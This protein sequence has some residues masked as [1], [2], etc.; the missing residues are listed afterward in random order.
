MHPSAPDLT[1]ILL[2]I[3]HMATN[4]SIPEGTVFT[5]F[6]VL[7]EA[8]PDKDNR[9]RVRAVCA[10]GTQKIVYVRHLK[11]GASRS[12]GCKQWDGKHHRSK[13]RQ[14][15]IWSAMIQ[16]CHNPN[17]QNF[18]NY[19]GRGI[20]VC[21]EWRNSF[22]QFFSDM[23]DMESIGANLTIDRIDNSV[24]Y[25]KSNCRWATR[26]DQSRNLRNNVWFETSRGKMLASQI[27]DIAGTTSSVIRYRIRNGWSGENIFLPPS[28]MNRSYSFALR[29]AT[30]EPASITLLQ[31]EN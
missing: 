22:D 30:S 14:Y 24:G 8:K 6:T 11:S 5:L 29:R 3:R 12:C 13:T 16:R 31:I 4:N 19:G 21:E 18:E 28:Q 10:C 27:A 26:R 25:K 20:H 17:S 23:G 1:P 15:N 9:P 2:E 7:G